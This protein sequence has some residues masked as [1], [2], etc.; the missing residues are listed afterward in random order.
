M[1]L[2]IKFK[3]L[4]FIYS[5]TARILIWQNDFAQNPGYFLLF[6]AHFDR[7]ELCSRQMMILQVGYALFRTRIPSMTAE[8][9]ERSELLTSWQLALLFTTDCP[10]LL[11]GRLKV[12]LE[13]TMSVFRMPSHDC[14]D[15]TALII[16][17]HGIAYR[18]GQA[19]LAWR[20]AENPKVSAS[21]SF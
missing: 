5:S 12:L 4:V 16:G 13:K 7:I 1:S 14:F 21:R 17:L 9:R 2:I 10:E 3:S 6:S 11:S 8:D 20:I 15:Q 18:I 19:P